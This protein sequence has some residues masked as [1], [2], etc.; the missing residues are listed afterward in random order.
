MNDA[1]LIIVL[2]AALI[3]GAIV[4][5][6]GVLTAITA[7]IHRAAGRSILMPQTRQDRAGATRDE[8]EAVDTLQ[9]IREAQRQL[10]SAH[11]GLQVPPEGLAEA[12]PA[13]TASSTRKNRTPG[14]GWC[15]G[16]RKAIFGKK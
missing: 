11:F 5:A 4:G 3:A 9:G 6:V 7:A 8:L 14:C 12:S 15:L 1:P 10:V 16:L 2:I 13:P